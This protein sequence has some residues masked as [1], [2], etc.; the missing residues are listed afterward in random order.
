MPTIDFLGGHVAIV[1]FWG[2]YCTLYRGFSFLLVVLVLEVWGRFCLGNCM[3][4]VLGWGR[5]CLVDRYYCSLWFVVCMYS[6]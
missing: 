5:F 1:L 4:T 3:G 2:G 6:R